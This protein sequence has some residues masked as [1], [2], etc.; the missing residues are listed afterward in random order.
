MLP[1]HLR[2][3]SFNTF[4][5]KETCKQCKA[6]KGTAQLE[7]FIFNKSQLAIAR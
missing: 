5:L 6:E 7:S 2:D 4:V 3:F 1:F